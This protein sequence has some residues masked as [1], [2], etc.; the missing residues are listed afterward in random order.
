MKN[1]YNSPKKLLE[2]P[3]EAI[4][5]SFPGH[6]YWK[7]KEGIY[8]GCNE[9]QAKSLGFSHPSEV[10]G[11]T[12]YDFIW[13]EQAEQLRHLDLQV[14]DSR[15][16]HIQEEE[17]DTQ[18]GR[19]RIFISKKMPLLDA[20]GDVIGII[21]T[22]LDITIQK[23]AEEML[24]QAKIK[25]E[26]ASQIK[27]E[28][29]ANMS[30]DLRTPLSGMQALAEDIILKTQDED[31]ATNAS[32]LLQ[33]S[34]DLLTLIDDILQ[35]SRLDAGQEKLSSHPF[36]LAPLVHNT[37]SIMK[38]KALKRSI[39]LTLTYDEKLPAQ[40]IGDH[41]VLQRILV[42]LLGNALKFTAEHGFVDVLVKLNHIK[43]SECYIDFIVV[44]TGIGIP[45]DKLDFIFEKFYRVA[46]SPQSRYAGS[47]MG[48]YMVKHYVTQM[49]GQID[50]V[51]QEDEGSQFHCEI[52][53]KIVNTDV[54]EQQ[55]KKLD[56]RL[57]PLE[58]KR[59]AAIHVL[60]VEDNKVVQHSQLNKLRELDCEVILAENATDALSYFERCKF[61]LL[62]VDLGLP[63]MDGLT[64]I[65]RFRKMSNNPN[66]LLPIILLTAHATPADLEKSELSGV[67]ELLIKP[68]MI[69]KLK[70]LL[71]DYVC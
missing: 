14:M 68:L 15:V 22:S 71:R 39:K 34:R 50:V 13:A 2:I 26:Q 46:N 40:V 5:S 9:E 55:K 33:A 3:L 49:G 51:S 52:P 28:F 10:V 60:V 41:L 57:S 24:R 43:N 8:L 38:P 69:D 59:S 11:K 45:A 42:N 66:H 12:D 65:Q 30:H 18:V 54:A 63:D 31:I 37:L 70:Q 67:T 4:V 27:S 61:D 44:D 35:A 62:I 6:L 47:G 25:A 53:F 36:M 16:P 23:E 64:L 21:G 19:K 17:V 58:E 20:T 56:L 32:L 29:I 48:L 1:L 7:N